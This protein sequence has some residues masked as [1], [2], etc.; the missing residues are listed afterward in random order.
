VSHDLKNP[1]ATIGLGAHLLRQ[2]S[3]IDTA[4]ISKLADTIQ[5]AVDKMQVLIGDLLDFDRIQSGTFSVETSPQTLRRFAAPVIEGFR[6]LA[7]HKRQTLEMDI[8]SNLPEVAVDAHRIGQ[9]ISNLLSNAIKFTPEGGTIRV[10]ARQEDDHLVVSVKD[11]GPGMPRE[12]LCKIFDWF[13]QAESTKQMGVGLGLSIAK[14][15]VE[16]HRGRIW[17]DSELGQGS[18][19]SFTLP[20]AASASLKSA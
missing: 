20:L 6:L 2:S 4:K 10:S 14:G 19:F 9:V 16:A 18:S 3:W 5:R 17:V 12:H 15:I 11:T 8:P 13:W 7:E 1:V